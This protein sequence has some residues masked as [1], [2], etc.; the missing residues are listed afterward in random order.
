MKLKSLALSSLLLA[1]AGSATAAGKV[2]VY[3]WS[4]YIPEGV[5]ERFTKETG[6]EV[7]YSNYE[8]NEVMYSKIQL[9]KGKG[10]DIVVPSSY[11]INKMSKEG[12]LQKIDKNQLS[13]FKHMNR[14]LL[15][16]PY[17]PGNQY[18]VPYLW[19]STGIGF[20][21]TAVEPGTITRW[22]DLWDPKWK[23]KLI[24]TDDVREVFHMALKVNGHSAN[25]TDPEEIRL[26]Y[27][28]LKELMPNVLLFNSDAPR[29]PFMAGD[30]NLGMIWNGEVVM[31]QQEM[32][33][34]Q[35]VYPAEGTIFWVD[36]F[37]IPVGSEN[38]REAHKFIDFMLQPDIAKLC[39]EEIGY[40]TPNLAAA[41]LLDEATRSNKTIFPDPDVFVKG[42]FQSNVGEALTIYNDYWEKLKTGH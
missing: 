1:V 21:A 38:T 3:N 20:N 25:S 39:S 8:S 41:K 35:Y 2:V 26:A 24:L 4:E 6:I 28:K 23:G 16:K 36:S 33:E 17:D 7:E 15:N 29:E 10:Y 30:V 19:G 40:A 42:E 13:Q 18:S 22:A 37:A 31:A 27:E 5:I 14:S 12:L 34:I 32:P 11:Y 9:Q